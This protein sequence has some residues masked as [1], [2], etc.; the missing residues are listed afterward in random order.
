MMATEGSR[1]NFMFLAPP[2]PATGSTTEQNIE[3][4]TN[5]LFWQHHDQMIIYQ[6]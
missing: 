4:G 3:I 5:N 6:I 1:I 2:Y